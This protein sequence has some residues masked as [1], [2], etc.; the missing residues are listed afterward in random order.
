MRRAAATVAF[1]VHG[2]GQSSA[3]GTKWGGLTGCATR[4]RARPRSC[5]VYLD[6]AIAEEEEARIARAGA[7]SSS[8]RKIAIL[9]A[10]VSG[11]H[12]CTKS[13]SAAAWARLGVV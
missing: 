7:A 2:A 9:S 5:L 13:A 11:P 6:A 12:S 4:Q 10:R 3:I 8:A 1:D